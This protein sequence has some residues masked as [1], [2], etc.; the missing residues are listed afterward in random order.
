MTGYAGA[1]E[2][3]TLTNQCFRRVLFTGPNAQLVVMSLKPGED[4]GD[5]VHEGV[6]QFFSIEQGE[7]QF[8]LDGTAT[9]PAARGD[10]VMVPMGTRHNVTNSSATRA[11]KLYTIYSPPNHPDGTVHRTRADAMAAGAT[12]PA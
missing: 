10:G 11:L 3:Q 6:D 12:Q 9:H 4:I 5:E 1:I 2:D 7:A 8:L